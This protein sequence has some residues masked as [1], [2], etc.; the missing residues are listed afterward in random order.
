MD[1]L[2][3]TLADLAIIGILLVSAVLAFARGF[4]HEVLSMA[5]WVGAAL[6]VVFGLPYARPIARE[7]I[8]LPLLADVAAGGVLFIVALLLLSLLTRAAA[9]TVQDSALNAV[10]RSLGFLFGLLRG[11]LLVCLAY[12][13]IAWLIAPA[14]QPDWM[15]NARARPLVERGANTLQSLI[16][17]D[18]LPMTQASDPQRTRAI[19]AL[20]TE[21]MVR[22]IITPDPKSPQNSGKQ[23]PGGY[24]EGERRELERLIDSDR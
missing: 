19:K 18:P 13:P 7:F 14:E 3:F 23:K 15:R 17:S 22:D 10:D 11:A 24:S 20:E 2:P 12:I 16:K 9:R 4:V 1:N 6:A 21:R 5:A 8:T